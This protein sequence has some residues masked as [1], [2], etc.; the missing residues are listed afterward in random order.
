MYSERAQQFDCSHLA[1]R[2]WV[3]HALREPHE[4]FIKIE[5]RFHKMKVFPEPH[6]IIGISLT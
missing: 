3:A 2:G 1:V 6:S 4:L 5:F